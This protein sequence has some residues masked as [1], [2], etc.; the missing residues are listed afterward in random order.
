MLNHILSFDLGEKE[1]LISAR[2][3]LLKHF[4]LF[5]D[6]FRPNKTLK[7][8]LNNEISKLGRAKTRAMV[9]EAFNDWARY[10]PLQFAEARPNEKADFQ[11]GFFSGDHDDG[12]AFDG[13]GG[14]LAH[15][16]F[17]TDGRIHFDLLEEWTDK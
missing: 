11:I 9:V 3:N 16:F 13:V 5:P 1:K 10:A 2:R 15:A 6:V 12:Y 14:T 17:P 8:N 4:L 7:W